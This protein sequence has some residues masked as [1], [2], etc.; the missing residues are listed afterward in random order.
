MS[1]YSNCYCLVGSPGMK[2]GPKTMKIDKKCN[3]LQIFLKKVWR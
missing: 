2:K 3:F 1:F